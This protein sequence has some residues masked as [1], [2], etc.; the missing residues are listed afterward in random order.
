MQGNVKVRL[1]PVKKIPLKPPLI[2]GDLTFTP[3]TKGALI[4]PPFEKGGRG[5]FETKGISY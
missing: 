1:N 3:L 4:F 5:D 2:K